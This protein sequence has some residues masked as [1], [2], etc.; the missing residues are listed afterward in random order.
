MKRSLSH[1]PYFVLLLPVFFVLHGYLENFGWIEPGACAL[2]AGE[3]IGAAALCCGVSSLYYRDLVKAALMTVCL[4]AIYFFFGAVHDF[5]YNHSIFL[6]RYAILLPLLAGL[7]IFVFVALKRAGGAGGTEGTERGA[8]GAGRARQTFP[9]ITLFLN[10]LLILYILTDGARIV[11]KAIHPDPDKLSVYNLLPAAGYRTCDTCANPDIYFLLFDEYASSAA[12]K[13]VYGYDNSAFDRWLEGNGFHIVTGSRGNYNYTPFCMASILNMSYLHGFRTG[14]G[15]DVRDFAS[16]NTLIRHN[17]VLRY[18]GS[19][20]YEVVNLSIFDLAGNPSP[21]NQFLLPVKTNLITER[22]LFYS[23]YRDLGWHLY[24]LPAP[25]SKVFGNITYKSLKDNNAILE[26][27]EEAGMHKGSTPRFIYSH[28]EMPHSPFYYDAQRHSKPEQQLVKE[29]FQTGDPK[30][31]LGY[32]PYTNR[33][34]MELVTSI[35]RHTHDSAVIIVMGDH[36]FRDNIPDSGYAHHFQNLNAV[37][38]P[39]RDYHLFYDSM[40]GV[41]QFRVLFNKL[42]GQNFRLLSDSTITLRDNR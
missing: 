24:T 41:N 22:T 17:E 8:R 28:F 37:F 31:Y 38:I 20:G 6:H 7:L 27:T 12:L 25:I 14:A 23:V 34:I 5:L 18:L 33:K 16:C 19:R 32:L 39:D 1:I 26:Q 11:W 36:G 9:R 30:P 10:T 29:M 40:T 35:R 3:Y 13:Q 2:L 15:V 4:F 42:F 21:F